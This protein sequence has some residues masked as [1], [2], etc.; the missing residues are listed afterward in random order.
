[1]SDS[2]VDTI[3][4]SVESGSTSASGELW[5][6]ENAHDLLR[7]VR[8]FVLLAKMQ[9]APIAGTSRYA[10]AV[11]FRALPRAATS[12]ARRTNSNMLLTSWTTTSSRKPSPQC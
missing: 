12:V 2:V 8:G 3:E 10:A 9:L 11:H 1:M 7:A 4:D 5:A 6:E